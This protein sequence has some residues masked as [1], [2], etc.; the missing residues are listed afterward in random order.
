MS[1]RDFPPNEAPSLS[2]IDA[3]LDCETTRGALLL[4]ST[5]VTLAAV[6]HWTASGTPVVGTTPG[7]LRPDGLLTLLKGDAAARPRACIIFSDQL[8]SPV[9]AP[10]LI[11][12]G[13][14]RQYMSALELLCHT[15]LGFPIT[16]WTGTSFEAAPSY[17]E[18]DALLRLLVRHREACDAL[19]SEWIM[20]DAQAE[21]R[22]SHRLN[23]ARR[24]LQLF[25]SVVLHS[26]RE[27]PLSIEYEGVVRRLAE[28][29]K[30]LN[31][32]A[33]LG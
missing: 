33:R 25:Q 1:D 5:S 28:M 24:R 3:R 26:F 6:P 17:W 15:R 12:R 30:S 23:D 20:R 22:A 16:A 2:V 13:D 11:Q 32:A 9:D 14:Q 31:A 21:S 10:L 27:G 8:V 18:P 4:P 7:T 29:R 19:G